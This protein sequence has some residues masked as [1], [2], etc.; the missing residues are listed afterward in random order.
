MIVEL[1]ESRDLPAG[2]QARM[3]AGLLAAIDAPRRKGRHRRVVRFAAATAVAAGAIAVV[4]VLLPGSASGPTAALAYSG[5]D[6]APAIQRAADQCLDDNRGYSEPGVDISGDLRLA[7]LLGRDGNIVVVFTTAG[8]A[9]YCFNESTVG[10]RS[11]TP[12]AFSNWMPGA[13]EIGAATSAVA[14]GTSDYFATAGR[15]SRRVTRLVLDHGNGRHTD[16]NLAGG[17]FVVI[18]AG[19]VDVAKTVLVAYDSAGTEIGRR[20]GWSRRGLSEQSADCYVDPTGA[21]VWGS[22]PGPTCQAAEVWR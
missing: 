20:E 21:V 13:V 2:R 10:G 14:E 18:A 3:R 8:G 6:I 7:N 15:V 11:M 9:L 22:T 17:T 16:A 12:R 5:G 1:P 19:D 4:P